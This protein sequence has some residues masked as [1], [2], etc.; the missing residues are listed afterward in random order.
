MCNLPFRNAIDEL[1]KQWSVVLFFRALERLV[2]GCR[3]ISPTRRFS[4]LE[5]S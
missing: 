5:E 2:F 3:I 1:L 4:G